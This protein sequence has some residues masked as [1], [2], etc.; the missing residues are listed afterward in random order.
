MAKHNDKEYQEKIKMTFRH[1][2]EKQLK[3]GI[4]QGLYA[5]SKI[6]HD[7]ATDKSKTPEERI[8]SIVA[9][10]NIALKQHEKKPEEPEKADK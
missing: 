8:E 5:A 3:T 9:F 2:L 7:R 6:I 4:A 10:C 1:N